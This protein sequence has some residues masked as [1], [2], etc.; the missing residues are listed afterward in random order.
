MAPSWTITIP[1]ARNPS[2]VALRRIP[3][4]APASAVYAAAQ[5]TRAL[6]LLAEQTSRVEWPSSVAEVATDLGC[7]VGA[8]SASGACSSRSTPAWN[9]SRIQ[10]RAP[11]G[12][13]LLTRRGGPVGLRKAGR[14][15]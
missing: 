8:R 13:E 7:V 5:R 1:C 3:G 9:G 10:G 11:S 12:A 4:I 6:W 15:T 14:P 2:P